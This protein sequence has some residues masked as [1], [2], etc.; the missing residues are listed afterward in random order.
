MSASELSQL[1]REAGM[2]STSSSPSS[3]GDKIQVEHILVITLSEATDKLCK[4]VVLGCL[5]VGR[6]LAE[7]FRILT[8]AASVSLLLW[9]TSRL[10]ESVRSSRSARRPASNNR[11]GDVQ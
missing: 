11:Y 4:G 9:G 7:S 5:E 10:I 1:M 3:G 2:T 6:K 8:M